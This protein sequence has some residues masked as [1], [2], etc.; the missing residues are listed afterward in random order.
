MNG[1]KNVKVFSLFFSGLLVFQAILFIKLQV[2]SLFVLCLVILSFSGANIYYLN[3]KYPV[4]SRHGLVISYLIYVAL[5]CYKTGGLYSIGIFMLFF[6]P[7]LVSV[8]DQS[9]NKMIYLGTAFGLI[10]VN[11]LGQVYHLE[12]FLSQTL[13]NISAFRFYHL[14]TFFGCFSGA[15]IVFLN[16]ANKSGIMLDQARQ[17]S[18]AIV[19]DAKHALQAKD[20][21]LANMS[22][23]IRNPMNGIIGMMHVLL[24]SELDEEQRNYADIVYSSARALLSIVN[25]ILDL[26]KIEA[27]KLELDI[28]GF[29]LELA[30][31]DIVSLP[32][33]LARQKGIDFVYSI[34]SIV[35][36]LLKGDIARIRQIILNLTGNAVKF[37]ESGQV[38]LS[39]SVESEDK[40]KATLKF[41]VEDTGIG[42]K[43]DQID[44]LFQSFTQAD[45]SITKKYGGTGLGLTIS[46]LLVEKMQGKMGVESID[47]IGS[48]FWF[49]LTLDKQSEEE[50]KVA[51]SFVDIE[52]SK[53][54]ILSD[55]A[56]LGKTF[57]NNLI[58]LNIDYEQAFDEI[59]AFEMLKW[60][61]EEKQPYHLVIT[62]A[63]ECDIIC[64]SLGKKIFQEKLHQETKM[65]LLTSVGKKGDARRFEEI[66][67]SAFLSKPVEKSLLADTMRAVL[68][69]PFSTGAVNLPIITKYSI[70]ENKKHLRNILIV[71]DMATNRLMAKALIEKMGYKTDAAI[72]GKEAVEK[73]K[74]NAYDLILMDC[75]MPIMDGF[76][77]TR[78]IREYEQESKTD[79]VPIVAM[80]GNAFESDRKKCFDAGMDDFI[81]KPVEPDILA[82]KIA[83]NLKDPVLNQNDIKMPQP[84]KAF[85]AIGGNI[86]DID[87]DLDGLESDNVIPDSDNDD[88]ILCFDRE[89]LFERFGGD[90]E[91]MDLILE[92]FTEEGPELIQDLT[93]AIQTDDTEMVRSKA[94]ALKGTAA[95][96]NAERLRCAA[97]DLETQAKNQ[98]MESFSLKL[99]AI[100]QEY[101]QFV[102]KAK[103]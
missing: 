99:D 100:K 78:K 95:N 96:V 17:E 52:K 58:G 64:E 70:L 44:K 71:E 98:D 92:S 86:E 12:F 87:K 94:H 46:K 82:K 60:A 41:C 7:L 43:E 23:E 1:I 32:G 72:N 13:V 76:E 28:R 75:Q 47:M 69:R 36:C 11:Y 83:S 73:Q 26:S 63:K 25:D 56:S 80:T 9:K 55:G 4:F 35:P 97:L 42:I 34:D 49:T 85:E 16:Q 24:D 67:F 93:L 5:L 10:L 22:H 101:E 53:V 89:K 102:R 30:I 79:H 40:K 14:L 54:L 91:L 77:A 2:V 19:E 38:S 15:M 90:E 68:S 50:K 21:F 18:I 39:V 57:E 37:T 103:L 59:E 62:E 88:A 84:E 3:K 51:A 74:Q 45:S 20:E 81:A 66:G 61:S 33:L 29:D 8:F 48:V 6:I 31:K 65:M 27:G